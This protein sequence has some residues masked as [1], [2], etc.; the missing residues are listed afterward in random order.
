M[1][2]IYIISNIILDYNLYSK[3]SLIIII[4]IIFI[5]IFLN[6]YDILFCFW[7]YDVVDLN[8][9]LFSAN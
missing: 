8:D 7:E 3:L 6:Y 1:F 5:I 9:I 4:F 2:L